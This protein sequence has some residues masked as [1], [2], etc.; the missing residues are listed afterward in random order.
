M[1]RAKGA[2]PVA[3]LQV[4][5]VGADRGAG[6]NCVGSMFVNLGS[7]LLGAALLWAAAFVV[8]LVRG[9]FRR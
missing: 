9:F 6:M 5:R 4:L 1:G 2:G 7:A 8:K 3:R